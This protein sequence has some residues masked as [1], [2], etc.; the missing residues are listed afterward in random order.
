[1]GQP[2]FG[3]LERLFPNLVRVVLGVV[4]F[5]MLVNLKAYV[6]VFT[7]IKI[8]KNCFSLYDY[9]FLILGVYPI[10]LLFLDIGGLSLL[11][12]VIITPE[13]NGAATPNNHYHLEVKRYILFTTNLPKFF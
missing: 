11:L 8:M 2:P 10:P 3:I 5:V 12:N 4:L 7:I 1:M 13:Q 9:S 6:F